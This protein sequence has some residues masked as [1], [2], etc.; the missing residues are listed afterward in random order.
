MKNYVVEENGTNIV[1]NPN[2]ADIYIA[3]NEDVKHLENDVN[4]TAIT[5][6]YEYK[7]TD[8]D[9]QAVNVCMSETCN[10]KCSYCF[11]HGGTFDKSGAKMISFDTLKDA[12]HMIQKYSKTGLKTIG[13]YGGEPLM[14]F[15]VI[16]QFVEYVNDR[17]DSISWGIITNGTIL[18]DEMIS[19]FNKYRFYVSVSLDGP[20]QYNDLYRISGDGKSTY[21]KVEKNLLKIQNRKFM[22]SSQSTLSNAFFSN[23]KKGSI[24]EYFKT[25]SDLG[26]DNVLPAVADIEDGYSEEESGKITDFFKDVVDFSFECLLSEDRKYEPPVFIVKTIRTLASKQYEGECKAGIKYVF[27][28]VD[29][30]VYP[31]QMHYMSSVD[32]L[33][34]N[35]GV[36][37]KLKYTS[38]CDIDECK[39]CFCRN[40]CSVWCPGSSLMLNGTEKSIIPAR[41]TEQKAIVHQII[42]NLAKT[43]SD[44]DNWSTFV[45]NLVDFSLHYSVERYLNGC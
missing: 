38:R 44:Q 29:G 24:A 12:Y 16:K 36:I 25:Y 7:I 35:G 20:K 41:C 23:Y 39:S 5:C 33:S 19:F 28:T 8:M 37:P 2:T 3:S 40:L 31:C 43:K 4:S 17:N 42:I 21:D 26:I 6:T 14:N 18:N 1:F 30:D 32:C 27:L 22:L 13:F 10:L 11:F 34:G 45:K 15:S 9:I